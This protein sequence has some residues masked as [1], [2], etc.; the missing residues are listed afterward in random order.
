MS[1]DSDCSKYQIS[2]DRDTLGSAQKSARQISRS[3]SQHSPQ[4]QK[5]LRSEVI[6]T[7]V[8]LRELHGRPHVDQSQLDDV[9]RRLQKIARG[10]VG[11][12]RS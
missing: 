6:S 11:D 2:I 4:R 5:V 10:E 9:T 3:W 1:G 8:R 12:S 7:L